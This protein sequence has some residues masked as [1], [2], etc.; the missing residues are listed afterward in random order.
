[1]KNSQKCSNSY[2]T[3]QFWFFLENLNSKLTLK[4]FKGAVE[5][6]L[7][8][9]LKQ[10]KD[11]SKNVMNIRANIDTINKIDYSC[12]MI[13]RKDGIS[14]MSDD[15][16]ILFAHSIKTIGLNYQSMAMLFLANNYT[17]MIPHKDSLVK[18]IDIDI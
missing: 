16:K 14:Y 6:I 4:S 18:S 2:F 5:H 8:G 17:K 11:I 3:Q 15:H 9:K 12:Q 1:M 10:T 13:L 7:N